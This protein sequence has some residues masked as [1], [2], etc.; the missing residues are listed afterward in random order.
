M[1]YCLWISVISWL[2]KKELWKELFLL[3]EELIN[4]FIQPG[5]CMNKLIMV[6]HL[7]NTALLPL[8]CS[9]L[10]YSK[11]QLILYCVC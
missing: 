1:L 5:G 6:E 9:L 3:H 2:P 8:T 7:L 4:L 11:D 10:C